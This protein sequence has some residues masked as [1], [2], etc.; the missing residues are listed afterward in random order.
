MADNGLCLNITD[1]DFVFKIKCTTFGILWFCTYT[2]CTIKIYNFRGEST[3]TSA[4]TES[5]I[6]S[7]CLVSQLQEFL[8]GSCLSCCCSCVNVFWIRR[9][10]TVRLGAVFVSYP[11]CRIGDPDNHLFGLA[12]KR[13]YRIKISQIHFISCPKNSSWWEGSRNIG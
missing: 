9:S 1:N 7:T 3:D 4:T 6:T 5:L 10:H 8:D 13:L 12:K 2:F 11:I